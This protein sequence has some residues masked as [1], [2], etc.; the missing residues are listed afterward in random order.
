MYAKLV[1]INVVADHDGQ[2][3]KAGALFGFAKFSFVGQT[4]RGQVARVELS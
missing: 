2:F 4:Q 1:F 3:G